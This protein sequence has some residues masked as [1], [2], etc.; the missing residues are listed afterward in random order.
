LLS[1]CITEFA[2]L[3]DEDFSPSAIKTS[4]CAADKLKGTIA[5]SGTLRPVTRSGSS[6]LTAV[7]EKTI[8]VIANKAMVEN[9][10]KKPGVGE[11]DTRYILLHL[12]H[13]VVRKL[14]STR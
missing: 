5:A 12:A 11:W 8:A 7:A 3:A 1:M 14:R 10:I 4:W 6:A 13:F 9:L 2:I